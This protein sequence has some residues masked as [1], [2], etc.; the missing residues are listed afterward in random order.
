MDFSAVLSSGLAAIGDRWSLLIADALA[1]GPLRF[2]ELDG[3]LDGIAP[4]ILIQRLRHLEHH[5]LVVSTPY[6]MRPVRMSYRLTEDG[7]RLQPVLAALA[8][9]SARRT[10]VEPPLHSACGTAL[11][12]RLWCPTCELVV[13][14]DHD[15]LHHV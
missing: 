1:D 12:T 2:G 5:G 8:Q 6:S 9:W 13:D 15:E 11:E 10:G 4:N 14:P 3:R 7:R